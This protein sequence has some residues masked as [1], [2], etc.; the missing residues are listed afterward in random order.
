[1]NNSSEVSI[2]GLVESSENHSFNNPNDFWKA[3]SPFPNSEKSPSTKLSLKEDYSPFA[4]LSHRPAQI[5]SGPRRSTEELRHSLNVC[6]SVRLCGGVCRDVL[7]KCM[8]HSQK[9]KAVK[10]TSRSKTRTVSHQNREK[11]SLSHQ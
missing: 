10:L 5:L 7:C 3:F 11:I 9:R 1:M 6:M 4:P 8:Q 2:S